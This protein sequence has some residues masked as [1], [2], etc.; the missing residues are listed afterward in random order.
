MSDQGDNCF[1]AKK[2]KKNSVR[3]THFSSA[4][5]KERKSN[6]KTEQITQGEYDENKKKNFGSNSD[7][8]FDRL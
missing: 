8:R 3:T 1:I 4:S 6:V 2:N 5:V 7:D